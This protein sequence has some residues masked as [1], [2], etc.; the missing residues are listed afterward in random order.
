MKPR[1]DLDYEMIPRTCRR[2]E[3]I[4]MHLFDDEADDET[5]LCGTGVSIHDRIGVDYYLDRRKDGLRLGP[6]ARGARP[7]WYLSP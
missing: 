2:Y 4:V 7:W 5:P 3:V 6:C 1:N